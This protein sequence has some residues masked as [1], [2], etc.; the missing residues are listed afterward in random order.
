MIASRRDGWLERF[1]YVWYPLCALT[2][3]ALAILAAAGY[4]YTAR[5]LVV[6]L[7]L[8]VYVLVG[9]IV[10]RALLLRWTLVNQRKL[11]IEQARQRRAAAQSENAAGEDAAD[12]PTSNTPERD[13]AAINTQTRRMIEYSL[14]VA[15][16]LAVWCAWIDVLPALGSINVTVWRTTVTV[17]EEVSTPNGGKKLDVRDQLREITLANLCLAVIILAT[18]VTAAKN[19]PACWKWPYCNICPSTPAPA[20]PWPRSAAMSSPSWHVV[21]LRDPRRGLV[22]GPVAGGRHDPG[23]G[24]GLQEIFANFVSGLIILFERPVRVGD[25]VTIDNVTGVV[26]RIRMRATTI[27]DGDRKN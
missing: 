4:H 1:R 25:V 11:A 21:L 6:R 15:C 27:T 7:I 20:T 16:A 22:K 3:A 2:P 10:C 8:T 19:S 9:G 23:L 24:F 12:L 17:S 5:Q 13:L 26:S 18:T 14:G